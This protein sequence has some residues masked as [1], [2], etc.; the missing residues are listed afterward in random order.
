LTANDQPKLCDFGVAKILTGSD[1][2]T[3]SGILIGTAEYMA[4]EQAT[5]R[6][7]VGPAA[8]VY[9]L[10]A[11]LYTLLVGRPPFQGASPLDT[12]AEVAYHEPVPPR[13]MQQAVPRDL[14]TV[15]L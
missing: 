14:D 7:D 11:L 12:L 13:R 6:A 4:P 1:L 3:R 9:A 8:D 5:G 2:K 15:C 10:G